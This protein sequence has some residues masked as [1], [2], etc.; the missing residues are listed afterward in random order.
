MHQKKVQKDIHHAEEGGTSVE[1]L[2]LIR[3][4]DLAPPATAQVVSARERTECALGLLSVHLSALLTP[5]NQNPSPLNRHTCALAPSMP[6]CG[7]QGK[8]P[9]L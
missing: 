6:S 1:R 5:V 9:T 3:K 2:L 7:F 8:I 4:M